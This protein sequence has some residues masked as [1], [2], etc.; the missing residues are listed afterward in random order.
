MTE[1]KQFIVNVIEGKK[2]LVEEA[3]IE[4]EE[5]A[6]IHDENGISII[7]L[8][9]YYNE[10]DIAIFLSRHKSDLDF[11]EAVALGN[12]DLVQRIIQSDR[13]LLE[14]FSP[15]G[16]QAMHLAAFF[17]Q[18]HVLSYLINN[19][20]DVNSPSKN[21]QRVTPLHSAAAVNDEEAIRLLLNAGADP[22]AV[23]E[24]GFTALHAAAQNASFEMVKL[25]LNN[26]ADTSLM[27]STGKSA[28]DFAREK[29]AIEIEELLRSNL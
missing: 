1:V 15:D 25:L 29:N 23:Q 24:G 19:N 9:L 12:L 26:G 21:Q 6:S 27:T 5:L 16:F 8:A 3:I 22:N 18:T 14:S 11:F 10:P 28:L 13:S 17:H 20:A 7:M 2:E 4:N